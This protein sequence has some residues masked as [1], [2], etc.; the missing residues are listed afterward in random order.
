MAV[1]TTAPE[2]PNPNSD[3]E[4]IAECAEEEISVRGDSFL[5]IRSIK[6]LCLSA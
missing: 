2:E 5:V 6:E 3:F 4:R 1:I